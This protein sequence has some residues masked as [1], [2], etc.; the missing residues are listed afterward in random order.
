MIEEIGES[1]SVLASFTNGKILP[2]VFKWRN[3]KYSQLKL[4]SSWSDFEGQFKR[5]FFSVS[6]DTANLYELCFH[7]R[8][9]QWS[10]VRIHHE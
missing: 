4:A 2:L 5:V 10:L 9:F 3:R 6:V 1:V 8:N 7:T